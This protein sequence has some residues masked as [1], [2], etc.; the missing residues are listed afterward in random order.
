MRKLSETEA[1]DLGAAIS[2][3]ELWDSVQEMNVGK[4]PSPWPRWHSHRGLHQR[5]V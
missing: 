5:L 2:L 3:Q 4:S 1:A